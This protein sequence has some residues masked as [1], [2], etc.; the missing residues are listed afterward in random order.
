MKCY[1]D[2]VKINKFVKNFL[3]FNV[4]NKISIANLLPI[5]INV[6]RVSGY[7]NIICQIHFNRIKFSYIKKKTIIKNN[8]MLICINKTDLGS[9]IVHKMNKKKFN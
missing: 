4:L 5:I 8:S 2:G 7:I 3:F 1:V 9:K 6:N